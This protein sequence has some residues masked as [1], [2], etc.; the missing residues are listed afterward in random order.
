[1]GVHVPGLMGVISCSMAAKPVVLYLEK[2]RY[3]S[4]GMKDSGRANL[5]RIVI[6]KYS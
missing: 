2:G 6:A 3:R 5:S 4:V 1:M